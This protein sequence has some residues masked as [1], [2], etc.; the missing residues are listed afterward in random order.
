MPV[1]AGLGLLVV[2]Y[3]ATLLMPRAAWESWGIKEDR[4]VEMPGSLALLAA[5]VVFALGF[6]H[7]RRAEA[8]RILTWACLALAFV[9]FFGFGEEISWGQRIFGFSNNVGTGSFNK[10]NEINLHNLKL[11]SG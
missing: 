10:Q 6:A 2:F 7:L 1:T 11:F 9:F 4:L 8:P 5:A 3:Y